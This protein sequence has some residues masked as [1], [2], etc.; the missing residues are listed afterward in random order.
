MYERSGQRGSR[1]LEI[2]AE[3]QLVTRKVVIKNR[4]F[5]IICLFHVQTILVG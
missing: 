3:G 5:C 4:K 2:K 1:S